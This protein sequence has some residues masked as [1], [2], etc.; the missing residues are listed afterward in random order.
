[1]LSEISQMEKTNTVCLDLYI[2]LKKKKKNTYKRNRLTDPENKLAA[3]RE[4]GSGGRGE[5]GKED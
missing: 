2:E 4:E 1:M 5:M 3:T